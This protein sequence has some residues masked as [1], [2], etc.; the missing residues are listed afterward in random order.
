MRRMFLLAGTLAS[1]ALAFPLTSGIA[2]GTRTSTVPA[3]LVG[4]WGKMV[5]QATW[6][7][8][9]VYGELA[10]H[11][12]ITIAKTG[13]TTLVAPPPPP[14]YTLTTMPASTSG[15][16][17]V[18]GPTADGVCPARGSYTWNISGSTLV[19]KVV[20]DGC[21]PRRVLMT[22]GSWKRG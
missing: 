2:A 1:L 18:F 14:S 19:L 15:T 5:T 3:R 7:K 13:R 16:S 20:K 17:L 21:S 6:H 11:W 8:S 22:A 12:K 9:G 10:G 4:T